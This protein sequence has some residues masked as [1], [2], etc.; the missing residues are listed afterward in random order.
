MGNGG[1]GGSFE[2]A[3]DARSVFSGDVFPGKPGRVNPSHAGSG[4]GGWVCRAECDPFS[5]PVAVIPGA[6][7]GISPG[8]AIFHRLWGAALRSVNPI[9]PVWHH[10][11]CVWVGT[12]DHSGGFRA[13][14]PLVQIPIQRI[15]GDLPGRI[16]RGHGGGCVDIARCTG[17][18][19]GA[20][21]LAD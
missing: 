9:G 7:A 8:H 20:G 14:P 13:N 15:T 2:P 11:G 4:Y 3:R 10:L 18:F 1:D 21:H 12:C 19:M 5:E 16:W 6:L 17:V